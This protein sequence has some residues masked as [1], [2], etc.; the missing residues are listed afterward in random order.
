MLWPFLV[1]FNSLQGF[2]TKHFSSLFPCLFLFLFN[3]DFNALFT[4]CVLFFCFCPFYCLLKFTFYYSFTHRAVWSCTTG[5]WHSRWKAFRHCVQLIRTP[6][7]SSLQMQHASTL[8][9]SSWYRKWK[10]LM[11]YIIIL[12][13]ELLWWWWL[14]PFP[15]NPFPFGQ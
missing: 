14:N 3:I 4:S 6:S 8:T 13:S 12:Y 9:W 15:F 1:Y 2:L 11:H 7:S 5:K 10:T